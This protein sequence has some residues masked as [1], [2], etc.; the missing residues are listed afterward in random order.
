MLGSWIYIWTPNTVASSDEI[1]GM[2]KL[3]NQQ[4]NKNN[5]LNSIS[6]FHM[7]T[8]AAH[9]NQVF[10][11]IDRSIDPDADQSTV[12]D[13]E[14]ENIRTNIQNNCFDDERS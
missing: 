11:P 7:C 10:L 1:N 8:D 13:D 4:T 9:I 12:D 6:E 3:T 14:K 2:N 5:P